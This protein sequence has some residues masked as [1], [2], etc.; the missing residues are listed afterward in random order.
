MTAP[1]DGVRPER[2]R[3]GYE[4][5][6]GWR[7]IERVPPFTVVVL[8]DTGRGDEPPPPFEARALRDLTADGL[9]ELLYVL[10]P[11][12]AFKVP[13]VLPDGD[14]DVPLLHVSLQVRSIYDFEPD[15]IVNQ[16]PALRQWR[17]E[18]GMLV[19]LL[20]LMGDRMEDGLHAFLFD[21]PAYES[22]DQY[23]WTL[24]A[25]ARTRIPL[26]DV[27]ST[28]R[29]GEV[30]QQLW[31]LVAR[32]AMPHLR[33]VEAMLRAR[34]AQIDGWVSQ[35][36]DLVMHHPELQRLEATWRG[37]RHLAEVVDDEVTVRLLSVDKR[38]LADDLR[39]GYARSRLFQL[40]HDDVERWSANARPASLLVVDQ[41]FGPSPFDVDLLDALGQLAAALRAPLVAAAS[42]ALFDSP[43][44]PGDLPWNLDAHFE[45]KASM[46]PFGALRDRAHAD[47]LVLALPRVRM[48]HP[49]RR[50]PYAVTGES[51]DERQAARDDILWGNPAY[52][53]AACAARTFV[54]DGWCARLAGIDRGGVAQW[55]PQV[56]DWTLRDLRVDATEWDVSDRRAEELARLGFV[57]VEHWRDAGHAVFRRL[58]TLRRLAG[59][60]ILSGHAGHGL[61]D[62]LPGV[63][64]ADRFAQLLDALVRERRRTAVF[65]YREDRAAEERQACEAAL[66]EWL[67]GYVAG[68]APTPERPLTSAELQLHDVPGFPETYRLTAAFVPAYRCPPLAEPLRIDTIVGAHA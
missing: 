8:A 9:D 61:T 46:A 49:Y 30:L 25:L 26:G 52:A 18:Q 40:L 11:T 4:Q 24:R 41:A 1:N 55:L 23:E 2:V 10:R 54:R 3:L 53:L 66:R 39:Y 67:A 13:S 68:A 12:L 29:Y 16:I 63:L 42:D 19:G 17:E 64:V 65:P 22:D 59:E 14:P 33:D 47:H 7:R 34:I 31:D 44:R 15:T 57:P 50:D 45:R 36:L 20:R 48:R 51:Y 21:P 27:E 37:L 56:L 35:Q 5:S 58:P 6:L 60:A 62:T 38:E 32:G 43:E 28:S